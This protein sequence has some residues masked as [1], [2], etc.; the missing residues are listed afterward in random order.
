MKKFRKRMLQAQSTEEV[1][2]LKKE[3]HIAEVDLNYTQYSPL[4]E[5]YIG[6]YQQK[7]S[8]DEEEASNIGAPRP[9]MWTEVEKCM[10][11]GTLNKLRN[12][13]AVITS[14]PTRPLEV[15]PAK[16]KAEL[17]SD[18]AGLNRRE[19]R[20]HMRGENTRSNNKSK[21]VGF[22]KN[23]AF[24]ALHAGPSYSKNVRNDEEG[25]D[26]DGGFFE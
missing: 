2:S 26:S 25:D 18:T 10:E 1:E 17:A 23:K 9:P 11:E 20:S 15:R 14:I 4:S 19:R 6:I 16:P 21:S 22:E 24:G 13:A 12:R 8:E 5:P 7:K 3:M